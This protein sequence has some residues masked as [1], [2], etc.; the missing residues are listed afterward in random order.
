[1]LRFGGAAGYYEVQLPPGTNEWRWEHIDPVF[2]FVERVDDVLRCALVPSAVVD[3][4][5]A[6]KEHG[7]PSEGLPGLAAH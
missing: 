4:L 5:A 1:M 6:A 2:S 3:R 7:L